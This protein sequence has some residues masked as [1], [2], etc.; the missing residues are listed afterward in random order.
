MAFDVRDGE[1]VAVLGPSGAGK[2]TLLNVIAGFE[3]LQ[4]GQIAI[5]GADIGALSPAVRPV[6]MVFQD[7]NVFLHLT[8]KQNVALGV[9]PNLRLS[10]AQQ[11][12]VDQALKRVGL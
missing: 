5:D 2:T 1:L 7:H 8:L 3:T 4:K 6:S 11:A 9:A 12:E 10:L